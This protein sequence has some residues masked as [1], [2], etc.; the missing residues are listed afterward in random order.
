MCQS[1]SVG[2]IQDRLSLTGGTFITIFIQIWL[3]GEV[4]TDSQSV[5]PQYIKLFYPIVQ[6]RF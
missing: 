3:S 5:H 6:N 1:S 4:T 2:V